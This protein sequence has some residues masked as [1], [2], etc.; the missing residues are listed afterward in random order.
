MTRLNQNIEKP[1]QNIEKPFLK[2]NI[3]WDFCHIKL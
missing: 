3:Y 2:G 1:N